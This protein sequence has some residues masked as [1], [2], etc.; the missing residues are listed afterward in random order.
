M[1]TYDDAKRQEN[2]NKHGFDFVGCD[3]VFDGI[4]LTF[5]DRRSLYGESRFQTLGL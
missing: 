5:E 1:I 4:T 2:I 3:V